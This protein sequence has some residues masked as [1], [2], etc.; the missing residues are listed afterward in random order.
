[1]TDSFIC[2]SGFHSVHANVQQYSRAQ[3]DCS[4]SWL[5]NRLQVRRTESP[6]VSCRVASDGSVQVRPSHCNTAPHE[7]AQQVT[8]IVSHLVLSGRRP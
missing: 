1:L 3:A 5:G 2:R 4:S 6:T 7:L 8:H